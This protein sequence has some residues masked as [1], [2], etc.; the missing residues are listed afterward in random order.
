MYMS[1]QADLIQV[2]QDLS[3]CRDQD[4]IVGVLRGAA[5]RL[6]HADGITVV[7]RDG[8]YCHYVDEDAVGPLW[9]GRRFPLD[10]CISGWCMLHKQS[11]IIADIYADPR[12]PQDAY[13]PTFVKSLAMV[14]IRKEN[15]VGA[16]GAYWKENRTASDE[17]ILILESLGNSASMAFWNVQLIAMLNNA[18]A[19]KD[20]FISMLGHELRNPLAVIRTASELISRTGGANVTGHADTI[21]RQLR[22]LCR[23]VDDLLDISRLSSGK[24]TLKKGA[25]DLSTIVRQCISDRRA[26]YADRAASVLTSGLDQ[27]L[28]VEGDQTRLTQIFENIIDNAL[29]FTSADGIVSVEANAADGSV[30]IVVKDNGE[31]IEGSILAHLFETF[32]QADRSLARTRGGLGLGLSLVKGLVDLHG[33]S[34][35]IESAGK[36]MG[37]A[38]T[39]VIPIGQLSK[40]KAPQE[41]GQ[42]TA[43]SGVRGKVLVIEDNRDM[44]EGLRD[45][46]EFA[47]FETTVVHNGAAG[48]AAANEFMPHVVVCDLGLPIMDGFAVA[49]ALRKND[50][51]RNTKLIAVTGYGSEEDHNRAIEN[52]FDK[53]F[54][55]PFEAAEL[56]AEVKTGIPPK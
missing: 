13:R 52:G 50:A 2:I 12:I 18:S 22:H 51:F 33:G 10:T 5:R 11:A 42:I 49:E 9:K 4:S 24:I 55:K 37:T 45:M 7:L 41:S 48:V 17:E 53:H 43:G 40:E 30:R 27:E 14:P 35:E 31:G 1:L 23:V 39:I 29:K 44:A 6:T 16:I 36:G 25:V 34:I 46:L 47:G 38:V 3:F 19:R 21:N 56:L 20:E 32:T 15:P 54:V 28:L 26:L 8:E